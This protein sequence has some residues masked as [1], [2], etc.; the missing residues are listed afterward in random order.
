MNVRATL[1]YDGTHFLGFQRQA[2]GRTVQGEVEAALQRVCKEAVGII[3]AGRTDTGV[4]ATGQVIAF[5]AKWTHP[6]DRLQRALNSSL[7]DDVAIRALA[8]CDENF[9]PRFSAVSRTYEYTLRVVDVQNPLWRY[10]AWQVTQPL[11]VAAMNAAAMRLIGEHDFRSFGSPTV[12]ESTV[13]RVMRASWQVLAVGELRFTIEANA[14]LFR[15]VRRIVG[16][17]V[18]VGQGKILLEEIDRMLEARN[19]DLVKVVAPACGLCL[20]NVSY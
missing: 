11:D 8:Q 19:P 1:A 14:F 9:H 7:P 12:G 13:R 4:H 5:D 3:G 2:S 6:L 15:M 17:L 18:R 10:Y 16:T 20:V